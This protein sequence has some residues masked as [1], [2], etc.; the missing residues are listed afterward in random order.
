[1]TVD[2]GQTDEQEWHHHHRVDLRTGAP[3]DGFE[4]YSGDGFDFEPLGDGTWITSDPNGNTV[5]CLSLGP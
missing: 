4:V 2:H 1:M 3:V 5:R